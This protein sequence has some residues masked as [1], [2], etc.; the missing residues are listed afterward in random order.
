MMLCLPTAASMILAFYGDKEPPRKLKVLSRHK[1]YTS[2]DDF[3]YDFTVTDYRDIID[4]VGS[5]GYAW[6]IM[7]FQNRPAGLKAG[8]QLIESELRRGHP[9]IVSVSRTDIEHALVVTGFDSTQ[10]LVFVS[11]PNVDGDGVHPESYDDFGRTWNDRST[12]SDIRSLIVTSPK[13]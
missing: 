10:R 8:I 13:Q 4:A 6:R 5:L 11:D 12:G 9:M 1:K 2:D 7:T 3:L